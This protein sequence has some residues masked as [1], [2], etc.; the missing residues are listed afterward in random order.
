MNA[1]ERLQAGRAATFE[2]RFEEALE[3]FLWF[4]DHALQEDSAFSGVRL[5]FAL[6]YWLELAEQYAPAMEAFRARRDA[7]VAIL[8]AGQLDRGLFHDVEAMSERLRE[9]EVTAILFDLLH[10]RS[11]DFALACA[12]IAVP[13]LVRTKRFALAREYMAEPKAHVE[14]LVQELLRDIGEI[15]ERPRTRAPRFRAFIHIF[16]GDL[17][18]VLKVLRATGS[19]K[20]ATQLERRAIGSLK[21]KYIQNAVAKHLSEA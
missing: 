8:R 10:E 13:M 17:C 16:A 12:R 2:G 20:Q 11:P 19:S 9:D 5:S 7:K 15:E 4:H 14:R 21:L 18:D 1:R 3:H 6:G